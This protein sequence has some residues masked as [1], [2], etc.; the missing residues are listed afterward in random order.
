MQ[1]THKHT[2][3]EI[4]PRQAALGVM[5]LS[6]VSAW[7]ALFTNFVVGGSSL[8]IF[9]GGSV[10]FTALSLVYWRLNWHW[11]PMVMIIVLTLI[12]ASIPEPYVTQKLSLVVFSPSLLALM[13]LN[14]YWVIAS[15]LVVGSVLIARAGG[16]G[17]LGGDPVMLVIYGTSLLTMCV[18]RLVTTTALNESARNAANTEVARATAEQRATALG[19]AGAT[20]EQQIDEQQRL[21]NLVTTLETP[22]VALANRVLFAPIVGHMDTRRA[23][24]LTE[25]LLDAAHKQQGGHIILDIAGVSVIDSGVTDAII[26][27][28]QSL[29]LLGCNVVISGISADV[30]I[31]MTELGVALGSI[32]TVRTPQDALEAIQASSN[33]NVA[34]ALVRA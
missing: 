15:G 16:Q 23:Q 21:L 31:T 1:D 26:R 19:Q 34:R 6:A 27:T 33:L 22:V 12:V 28:A 30:A 10:L 20:M 24:S 14:E 9:F 2:V 11:A 13:L 32:Q 18:I 25:R 3:L 4:T 7:L 17:P 5:M 29:R 8:Y